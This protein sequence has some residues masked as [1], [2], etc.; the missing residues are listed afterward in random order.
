MAPANGQKKSRRFI[1]SKEAADELGVLPST[2]WR[3]IREK[4]KNCFPT[5]RV[6]Q[7][8]L[9]PRQKFED[10]CETTDTI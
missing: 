5:K 10:W 7:K 6:G 8:I 1:S 9:I 3:W 4:K 2:V